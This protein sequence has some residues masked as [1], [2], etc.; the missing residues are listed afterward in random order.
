MIKTP[1]NF[2]NLKIMKR[3]I[4]LIIS[5]FLLSGIMLSSCDDSAEGV[6]FDVGDGIHAA[7]PSTVLYLGI[8]DTDNNQ[9]KVP[10]VRGGNINSAAT[11]QVALTEASSYGGLFR[12][13][14]PDV[15]FEAGERNAYAIIIYDD[16]NALDPATQYAL[17]LDLTNLD[18][19]SISEQKRITVRSS[20]VLTFEPY[21]AGT[22]TSEW[23][24]FED[25]AVDIH[26]AVGLNVYR[27]KDAYFDG[28][29]IDFAVRPD[30]SIAFATQAYGWVHSTHGMVS[31]TMPAATS[32]LQPYRD[33][34][35][36]YLYARYRVPAGFFGGV[37]EEV[38]TFEHP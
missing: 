26:K 27:I 6:I 31:I 17:V 18:Q 34:N 22:F 16:L 1:F 9:I 20:L 30:N 15:V 24:E 19:V 37:W 28:Y 36:Y 25:K 7:W 10:V 33:G 23:E 8:R 14:S 2:N 29:D 21:T 11:V 32:E 35:N 38:V 3:S 4:Y 13:A 5:V 12:L